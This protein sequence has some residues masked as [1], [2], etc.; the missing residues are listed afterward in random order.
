M[1]IFNVTGICL[2]ENHYMVDIGGKIAEI[3]KLVDN[4][5]YFTINR[6]RQYGKTTTLYEL[7]KRLSGEYIVAKISFEGLGDESFASAEQFCLE[8]ME[9]EG[10][11]IFE[12][13]V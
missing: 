12:V 1:K 9:F 11:K 10:K 6:A 8:F 7:R 13:I 4:G 2:P 5:S 3:K